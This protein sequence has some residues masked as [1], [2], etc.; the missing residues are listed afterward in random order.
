MLIRT[1]VFYDFFESATGNY[2]PV[3]NSEIGFRIG[4]RQLVA[5][6]RFELTFFKTGT[7]G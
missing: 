7:V 5:G 2:L 4:N 1:F 3:A 6:C